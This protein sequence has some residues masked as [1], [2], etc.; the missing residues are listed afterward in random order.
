MALAPQP[1][2]SP[3]IVMPDRS[4]ALA[5][6]V[7]LCH[8]GVDAATGLATD[9]LNQ[10]NEL[11]MCLGIVAQ[12]ADLLAEILAWQPRSYEAHFH[13]TGFTDTAFII[14]AYCL[15]PV[16]CRSRFDTQTGQLN[17]TIAEGL[18]AIARSAT[19]RRAGTDLEN[20]AL[21]LAGEVERQV[22]AL[23]GI[24]NGARSETQDS[25]DALFADAARADIDALFDDAPGASTSQAD[26]DALFD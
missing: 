15:S 7:A 6:V 9:F 17:A 8:S 21:W 11:S 24:I 22:L 25:V 5:D 14:E 13:A 16:E 23:G 18:T 12:D 20:T 1:V 4:L 2:A 19:D 3:S 10:Y 26:I